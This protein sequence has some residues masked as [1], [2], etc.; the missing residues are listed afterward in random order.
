M[1]SLHRASLKLDSLLDF[2]A[3]Y[4]FIYFKLFKLGHL[5]LL[6]SY[7]SSYATNKSS[8]Y[9]PSGDLVYTIQLGTVINKS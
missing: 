5:M 3:V 8:V 1:Y 2:P 9:N 6:V 7:P 4:L